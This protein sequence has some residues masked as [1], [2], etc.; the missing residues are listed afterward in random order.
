MDQRTKAAEMRLLTL[1]AQFTVENIKRSEDI[2]QEL[3]INYN[4]SDRISEY[5]SE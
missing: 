1:V 5:R 3:Q 2:R 4:V